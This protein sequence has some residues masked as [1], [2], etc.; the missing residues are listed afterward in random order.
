MCTEGSFGGKFKVGKFFQLCNVKGLDKTTYL[1]NTIFFK[2]LQNSMT[3]DWHKKVDFVVGH[4]WKG[5]KYFSRKTYAKKYIYID[6]FKKYFQLQRNEI[7]LIWHF[8]GE[9]RLASSTKNLNK[10]TPQWTKDPNKIAI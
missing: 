6:F 10:Y 3:I 4:F 9:I 5:K 7:A 2:K 8:Q 1:N